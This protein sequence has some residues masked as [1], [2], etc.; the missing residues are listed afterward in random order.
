MS[1]KRDSGCQVSCPITS[2][3]KHL[4]ACNCVEAEEVTLCTRHL[5]SQPCQNKESSNVNKQGPHERRHEHVTKTNQC[6]QREGNYRVFKVCN[7][8]VSNSFIDVVNCEIW[9]LSCLAQLSAEIP[10]LLKGYRQ[11]KTEAD[12]WQPNCSEQHLARETNLLRVT[13]I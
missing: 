6:G 11:Q 12:W 8:A 9:S 10:K 3:P 2:V 13:W 7:C 1:E 5:Y 4:C